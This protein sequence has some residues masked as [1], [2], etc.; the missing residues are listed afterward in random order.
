MEFV[1]NQ[2]RNNLDINIFIRVHPITP[3]MLTNIKNSE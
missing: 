1:A 2:N 3:L